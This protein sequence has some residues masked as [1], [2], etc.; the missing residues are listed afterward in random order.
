MASK[1]EKKT[2]PYTPD[3]DSGY[4]LGISPFKGLQQEGGLI[5]QLGG[6]YPSQEGFPPPFFSYEMMKKG[7]LWR[8][9][10]GLVSGW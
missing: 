5:K 6:V 8:I 4:L 7:E 10:P 9:I 3:I 1:I 2:T